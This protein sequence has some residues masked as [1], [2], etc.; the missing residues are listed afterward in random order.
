MKRQPYSRSS[1]FSPVNS[2]QGQAHDKSVCCSSPF[3]S[4]RF[5]YRAVIS[6]ALSLAF[7]T[8]PAAAINCQSYAAPG[9][10][11]HEC[12]KSNLMLQGSD[13]SGANLVDTDF[14]ST[15]L[16]DVNLVGANMEKATLIRSSLAGAKADKANF[17]R[18]EAYRTSFA[19]MQAP[20]ASFASAEMQRADFRGANLT[21]TD[22]QKAELGRADFGEAM[23]TGAKFPLANLSRADFRGAK[24]EGPLDFSG[25]FLFLTR[26]EG[27]DLSA[28]KGLEQ[29][30]IENTCGD[31]QTKLPSGLSTPKTWPCMFE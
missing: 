22:F 18:I 29:E 9:M 24:F 7:G 3:Q 20:A 11:W 8:G 26:F 21:G 16:R 4:V 1:T 23:I 14:T 17:A 12:D 27:V 2:C 15:D 25:A 31:P 13:L 28:A 19:G 30:Q 6:L 5:I 10:D